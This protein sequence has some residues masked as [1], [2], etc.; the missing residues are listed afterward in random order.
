MSLPVSDLR[1]SARIGGK[2]LTFNFGDYKFWQYWQSTPSPRFDPIQPKSTQSDPK[3]RLRGCKP[4]SSSEKST[5]HR[6]LRLILISRGSQKHHQ[7]SRSLLSVSLCFF[8]ARFT[9]ENLKTLCANR[10]K[11]ALF[12]MRINSESYFEPVIFIDLSIRVHPW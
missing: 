1:S 7:F 12:I 4:S 8:L 11:L 2:I 9:F 3:H 5:S 6:S 10:T